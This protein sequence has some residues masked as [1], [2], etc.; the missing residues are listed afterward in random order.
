MYL[1]YDCFIIGRNA[2][3]HSRVQVAL[4]LKILELVNFKI[5]KREQ[6]VDSKGLEGL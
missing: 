4:Q 3:E 2:A 5:R 1:Q 6:Y